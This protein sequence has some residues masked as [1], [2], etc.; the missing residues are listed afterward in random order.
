VIEHS[1][2]AESVQ[3]QNDAM[4]EMVGSLSDAEYAAACEDHAGATVGQVA[5]HV[6]EGYEQVGAWLGRIAGE[7]V[8]EPAAHAHPHDHPHDHDHP[9]THDA[10]ELGRD[11]VTERLRSSGQVVVARIG[12]LSEEQL[13][14]VPPA[15]PFANGEVPLALALRGLM[16]HLQEHLENMRTAVSAV[17]SG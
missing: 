17:H 1:T 10:V 8:E 5:G 12:A 15:S 4:V 16:G 2:L 3:R 7:A 6:I 11:E 13:R 9:H 14:W